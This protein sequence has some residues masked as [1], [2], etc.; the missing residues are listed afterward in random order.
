MFDMPVMA[1]ENQKPRSITPGCGMLR[2]QFRRQSEIE[3][4]GSHRGE[5]RVSAFKL[6]DVRR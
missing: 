3:I 1:V 2:D 4:G 5:F 6:Q